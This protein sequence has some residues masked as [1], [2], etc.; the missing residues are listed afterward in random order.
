MD[1]KDIIGSKDITRGGPLGFLTKIIQ[2]R[3]I[4][5]INNI[6]VKINNTIIKK[7]S[8]AL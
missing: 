1:G 8:E 6:I 3:Q 7:E 2:S 5:H 4:L